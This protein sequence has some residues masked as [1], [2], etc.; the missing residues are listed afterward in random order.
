MKS[1]ES[2]IDRNDLLI[3]ETLVKNARYSYAEI[4]RLTSISPSTVRERILQ[5]E[6]NSV[7]RKYRTILD[8]KIL[9]YGLEAFILIKVFS[10]KLKTFLEIV[11]DFKEVR[12]C[13]RITGSE[14]V[15]LKVI[16]K[17]QEHLQELLD[18]LMSY[19]DATT[20]LILSEVTER[21]EPVIR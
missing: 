9:G 6:Q 17:D 12:E 20:H 16:L 10:G 14:N 18:K 11:R 15:H 19:G 7:I 4:G 21:R 1:N 13:Y 5:L 3:L 2:M 8:Y